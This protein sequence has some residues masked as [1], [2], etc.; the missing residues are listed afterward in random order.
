MKKMVLVWGLV[1]WFSSST[2]AINSFPDHEFPKTDTSKVS[3]DFSEILSGGPPRDGIPSIDNPSYISFSEA[4]AW[5][6]D[7]EPVVAFSHNG[8]AR[9]YPLQILIFHEI[10]NDDIAG[11]PVTVTFCPLCNASIVF[12]RTLDDDV[13]DFGTT[14]RLRNSDLIMYDRQTET[15]WQQFTGR[16]MIGEHSE[17]L[18]TQ[19][20]SQ[21]I[22]Y[23]VFKAA[24][25][26]GEVLSRETGVSRPYGQNP[27]RG[28]DDIN[29]NPFLLRGSADPRLPP[30]ER[31]LSVEDGAAIQLVPLSVLEQSPIVHL[32][33]EDGQAV[34]FAAT[35]AKSALDDSIISES[36]DIPSAAAFSTL[37]DGNIL[38]FKMSEGL[39][40]DEQTGSEWNA[41]GTA[42]AGEFKGKQL[43]QVDRGVHFAFAWLRFDPDASVYKPE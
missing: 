4:D 35:S 17:R 36:R 43:V 13:L 27:Y 31:V 20:P 34:V 25:P 30:M 21:I 3:V 6:S 19:L 38:S 7:S 24:Y 29:S 1:A 2:F 8:T 23:S 15:W 28:Y 26:E 41:V 40:V 22:S 42:V 16:G 5:L 9:A 11:K 12:D 18:L 32:D 37:V 39:V 14:G 10:V 33:V